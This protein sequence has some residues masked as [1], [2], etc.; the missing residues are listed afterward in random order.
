MNIPTLSVKVGGMNRLRVVKELDFGLYLDG[1]DRGEILLPRR[2][3]PE[4]IQPEDFLDVFIYLDSEDRLIATTETPY[5]MAGEL[6]WLRVAAMTDIGAF[7]DWGLPKDLLLP[8]AEQR[9]RVARDR[10]YIVYVYFDT[11]SERLVA[12]TKINKFINPKSCRYKPGREVDLIIGNAFELGYNVIIDKSYCGVIYH[13]EIFQPITPG[14]RLKGFIKEVRSDGKIDAELQKSGS[15]GREALAEQI[16]AEL[17]AHDGFLP[18]GDSTP[19]EEIYARFRVSK[20]AFKRALGG[21]YRQRR[22]TLG[23]SGIRLVG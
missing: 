16:L 3:V 2:Y 19:P 7:L 14:L 6:A 10:S 11:T 12:S 8:F 15:H 9:E 21:L 1:K 20:K 18:L 17:A 5:A 22:I 13:N 23:P 4:G